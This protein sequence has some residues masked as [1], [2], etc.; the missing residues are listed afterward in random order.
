MHYN[1][2]WIWYNSNNYEYILFFKVYPFTLKKLDHE[3]E[4]IHHHVI[5]WFENIIVVRNIRT[6]L[7]KFCAISRSLGHEDPFLA[8]D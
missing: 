6:A 4:K 8:I 5:V 2:L 1:I 7:C 3:K